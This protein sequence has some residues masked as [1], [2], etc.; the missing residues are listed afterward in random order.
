MVPVVEHLALLRSDH[1]RIVLLEQRAAQVAADDLVRNAAQR[2]V[3]E[4]RVLD[5]LRAARTGL[6]RPLG[7]SA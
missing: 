7:Q 3:L 2:R 1:I 5:H 4:Q 6:V